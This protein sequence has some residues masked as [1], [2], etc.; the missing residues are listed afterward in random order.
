MHFTP[1]QINALPQVAEPCSSSAAQCRLV[2]LPP[3]RQPARPRT[4]GFTFLEL[5][6]VLL[7]IGVLAAMALPR[8]VTQSIN[9][10]AIAAKLAS[11]IRYTQSLSMSQG[12]RYRI[13]FLSTTTYQITDIIGVGTPIAHPI[14]GTAVISVAPATLSGTDI[15]FD[16]QGVPYNAAVALAANVVITLTAGS[17]T[18]T[19]TISPATG[20]VQ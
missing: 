6:A 4:H 8:V 11:D 17:D 15:T 9:L 18:R 3:T 10:S 16:S 19:L 20:R 2:A 7:V 1:D 5:V 14:T 12:Q 13:N